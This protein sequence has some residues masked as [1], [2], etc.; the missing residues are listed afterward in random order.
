M[1]LAIIGFLN[2][3]FLTIGT[4]YYVIC[5]LT[6]INKIR[7]I[8]DLTAFLPQA[9]IFYAF[10]TI[11]SMEEDT[12]GLY[13]PGCTWMFLGLSIVFYGLLY[14]VSKFIIFYL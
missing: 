6:S 3:L 10:E 7:W 11:F 1:L 2:S 14:I 12:P 4:T 8:F 13:N 9:W 5:F